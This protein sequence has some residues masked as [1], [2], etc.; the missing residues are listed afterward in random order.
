[1]EK[2]KL[3][4][5]KQSL[6]GISSPEQLDDYLKVTNP[7]LWVILIA[8]LFLL[9]GILVWSVFGTMTSKISLP[10]TAKNGIVTIQA[11]KRTVR[12][13]AAGMPVKI[14]DETSTI[15]S[16]SE[17]GPSDDSDIRILVRTT[18]P[19]GVYEV[20]IVTERISPYTFLFSEDL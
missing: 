2:K 10:G 15:I 13:L 17:E 6:E 7:G 19:D 4:F 14:L 5:R 9:I 16:V 11:D 12:N 20:E 1:M 18:L 8:P 3:L